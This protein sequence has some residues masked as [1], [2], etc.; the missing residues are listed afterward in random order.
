MFD[1]FFN[2]DWNFALGVGA[3]TGGTVI[4]IRE[5]QDGR[6]AFIGNQFSFFFSIWGAPA[7]S[8][9]LGAALPMSYLFTT[10]A[11]GN[12]LHGAGFFKQRWGSPNQPIEICVQDFQVLPNGNFAVA[13]GFSQ[14]CFDGPSCSYLPALLEIDPSRPGFDNTVVRAVSLRPGSPRH[15]SSHYPFGIDF[16]RLS[17][18]NAEGTLEMSYGNQF[19]RF[20]QWATAPDPGS[21]LA[22]ET[23]MRSF[24]FTLQLQDQPLSSVNLNGSDFSLH[25]A[26][27]R[28]F[29]SEVLCA[30]T[31]SAQE[32]DAPGPGELVAAPSVFR[33][34]FN[35][36]AM[37]PQ[38]V[39]ATYEIRDMQG[40][41]HQRGVILSERHEITA[42]GLPAGTY[43]I[44]A[45]KDARQAVLRVVKV[46]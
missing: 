44:R 14:I 2:Q 21:C 23:G 17:P 11:E 15:F 5:M 24:P 42:A 13:A 1:G 6:L 18:P 25:S 38:W 4:G 27:A 28:D 10:D 12:F 35:L 8:N 40:R 32:P 16:M 45:V 30:V 7:G 41:L 36:I 39:G 26:S 29:R 31:T 3:G 22:P 33:D 20:Y 9:G 37:Q 19:V 43:V 34:N 46:K